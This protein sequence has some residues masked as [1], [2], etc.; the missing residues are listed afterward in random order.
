MTSMKIE[1]LFGRY[2][3]RSAEKFS[4]Q[5]K[6]KDGLITPWRILPI[7]I[8][9]NTELVQASEMPKS[10]EDLLNPKWEGK[11]SIPD[12]SRHTTT[13]KFFWNLEKLMGSKWR[14]YVKSLAKQQPL[15]VESL[16]P[17]TPAI[18]KGEAQVGIA[19]IKFVKQYKGPV[20]YVSLNK[21]LSDPNHL[22]L[23]AKA[24]RPNAGRLY[25]EFAT[26]ADGQKLIA[27]D[28]EFVLAPG[29][30]PPIQGAE[31]VTPNMI[32]M[33]NPSEDEAK[34]LSNEFRQIFFAK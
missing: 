28:G 30:F 10:L 6:D 18:I 34:S 26:S 4:E 14:E 32:P 9:Y 21:Y 25:I 3:P 17:V 8:L 22:A 19:Y 5:F 31:K 16:A 33:D 7:S 13:A 29:V 11:I 2:L 27:Q 23:G 15:L 1:G 24:A 12:P 20:S